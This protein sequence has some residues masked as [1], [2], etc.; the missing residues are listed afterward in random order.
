MANGK[1]IYS[2]GREKL[3][4]AVDCL[5]SG[6]GSIQER[7]ESAAL[8]LIRLEPNNDEMPK[9]LH[10]ELEAILLDLTKMAAKGDEGKISATLRFMS[11]EEGSKLA[12]RIFSLYVH[13]H[14]GI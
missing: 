11:D 2:Y 9:E 7:L 4:Q 8:Y 13:L 1:N 12:G 14:G 10:L 6:T 5:V 3:W